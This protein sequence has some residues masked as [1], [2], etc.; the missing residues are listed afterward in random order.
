[1]ICCFK[2][3]TTFNRLAS[4]PVA[5][6]IFRRGSVLSNFFRCVGTVS[7]RAFAVA[8]EIECCCGGA[9]FGRGIVWFRGG[10]PSRVAR[11]V[12]VLAQGR[13][14]AEMMCRGGLVAKYVKNPKTEFYEL[15]GK[16]LYLA[17]Q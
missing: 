8:E 14:L 12:V 3:F 10:S 16:N 13:G 1:M 9:R 17:T 11:C 2:L 4:G 6:I 15:G 5:I 7:V